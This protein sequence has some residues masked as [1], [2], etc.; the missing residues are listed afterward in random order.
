M[1]KRTGMTK[2]ITECTSAI[3]YWHKQKGKELGRFGA[4]YE[5]GCFARALRNHLAYVREMT[6]PMHLGLISWR[7]KRKLN[8]DAQAERIIGDEAANRLLSRPYRPPWKL[9]A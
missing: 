1:K 6:V 5:I 7:L 2:K 3:N 9:P 4:S 8:W